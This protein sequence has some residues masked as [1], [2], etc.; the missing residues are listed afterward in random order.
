VHA[1]TSLADLDRTHDV[2]MGD[3]GAELRFT[4]KPRDGGLVLPEPLAKHLDGDN[5][6]LRVLGAVDCGGAPLANQ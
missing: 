6:M 2:R 3:A 1:W 5:A 4:Q